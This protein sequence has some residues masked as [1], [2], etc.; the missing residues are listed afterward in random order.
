MADQKKIEILCVTM[1]Q[2][3]LSKYQEMHISNCDVIFANQADSYAYSEQEIG[4]DRVR[5]LT[6]ATRGV[7]KNRNF[8]LALASK[9][10]L[11]FSDDDLQ[12]EPGVAEIV[13]SAFRE[14]PDAELIVFGTRYTKNGAVYKTRLP[15]TG[16]LPFLNALKYG[17]YAIAVR[18]TSVLKYNL[19]F[20][21]L[22]GGGCLYSYG[23]DTDFIVQCYKKHMKIYS[24]GA[25]IATT[26]KDTSTCYT[27]YGEKYYFDKGALA[28]HSL[29]L[30]AFPYMLRMAGKK[31]DSELSFFEKLYFLLQGYQHFP[32]LISYEGWKK[33]I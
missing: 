21:E 5:M 12:Y 7:G 22:F 8:A 6:T 10:L 1:H 27:G 31:L 23:E 19:R 32:A 18:R 16:R 17:T 2:S 11:L 25:I 24:Y 33:R 4:D 30:M 20:S 9:D 28:R 15:K 26:S 13:K 3:D 29:G 14:L